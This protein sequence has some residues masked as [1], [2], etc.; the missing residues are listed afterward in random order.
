MI[1]AARTE[2]PAAERFS[3]RI[4]SGEENAGLPDM[5]RIIAAASGKRQANRAVWLGR[6]QIVARKAGPLRLRSGQAPP[7]RR[8]WRSGCGRDDEVS[9]GGVVVQFGID[10]K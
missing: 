2:F 10:V 1:T 4:N 5:Q 3:V 7:L 6:P 8:D 9:K